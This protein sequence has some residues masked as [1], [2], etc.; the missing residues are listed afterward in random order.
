MMTMLNMTSMIISLTFLF[1][2][3]PL[4]MGMTLI[5]QTITLSLITGLIIKSF[6]FSYILLIIMLSGMLVLFIYMASVASNEKFNTS[7]KMTFLIL[8]LIMT[9]VIMTMMT[10]QIN[11]NSPE[12]ITKM[13]SINDQIMNLIKMY[14][15]HNM[16][17]TITVILYLLLTMVV[18]SYIVNVMEGPLRSKN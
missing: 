3:H 11:N 10:E 5:L 13:Y 8:L 9:S 18:I 12:K 16:S 17:I 7:I 1:T 15:N 4:S 6:W 14:N 2:K